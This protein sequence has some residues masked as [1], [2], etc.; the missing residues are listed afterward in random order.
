[1]QKTEMDQSRGFIAEVWG[2]NS[3]AACMLRAA[4]M[5]WRPVVQCNP[6]Y[7]EAAFETLK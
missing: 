3:V 5:P 7:D 2:L 4:V 6:G 1:M